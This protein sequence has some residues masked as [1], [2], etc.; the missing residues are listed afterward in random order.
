M[1]IHR[2]LYTST[3]T[4]IYTYLTS[5]RLLEQETFKKSLEMG[6]E[7]SKEPAKLL[8]KTGQFGQMSAF[9]WMDECQVWGQI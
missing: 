1:H 2:H 4:H 6:G 8:S 9:V 5:G 7:T 3:Y